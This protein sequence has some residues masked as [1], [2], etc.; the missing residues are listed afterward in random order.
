MPST[1]LRSSWLRLSHVDV[2]Q[3]HSP[4]AGGQGDGV[5]VPGSQARTLDQISWDLGS[6]HH[7]T[8]G[9]RMILTVD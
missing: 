6:Q 5:C 1:P 9:A 2:D 8:V 4:L 3:R 7:D